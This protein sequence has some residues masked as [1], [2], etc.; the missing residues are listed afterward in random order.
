MRISWPGLLV[1]VLSVP[2]N[3]SQ[4]VEMVDENRVAGTRAEVPRTH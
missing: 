4:E 3:C 1:S 2:N